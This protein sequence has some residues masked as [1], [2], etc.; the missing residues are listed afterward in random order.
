MKRRSYELFSSAFIRTGWRNPWLKTRTVVCL[1]IGLVTSA[2]PATNN[3]EPPAIQWEILAG[4][5]DDGSA[6]IKA[7]INPLM[8][9]LWTGFIVFCAGAVI[10][11]I[12]DPREA[13]QVARVQEQQDVV[14]A[15]A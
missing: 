6:T 3:Q 7:I 15:K 4:W 13:R 9:W 8:F 10:A 12:P 1:S 5:T 2:F 14:G 11:M